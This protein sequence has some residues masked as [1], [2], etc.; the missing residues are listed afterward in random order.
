MGRR[1]GI[2]PPSSGRLRPDVS[3]R[4]LP[5]RTILSRIHGTL[6]NPVESCHKRRT[7]SQLGD[8]AARSQRF[9]EKD[10][11]LRIVN[12]ALRALNFC[13]LATASGVPLRL[14][15]NSIIVTESETAEQ[16]SAANYR[17]HYQNL[18]IIHD[19]HTYP[20]Q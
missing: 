5:P 20:L 11:G 14:A 8:L 4:L 2:E 15:A 16:R 13:S 3:P 17:G 19:F 18:E 1:G 10:V 6:A 9:G 12:Q 7:R